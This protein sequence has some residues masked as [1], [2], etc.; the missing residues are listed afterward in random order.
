MN[1]LAGLENNPL[2]EESKMGRMVIASFVSHITMFF[3]L[4][5]LPSLPSRTLISPLPQYTSVKLVKMTD[6][7]G[8]KINSGNAFQLKKAKKE[9]MGKEPILIQKQV[10]IKKLKI[11]KRSESKKADLPKKKPS[12]SSKP[13]TDKKKTNKLSRKTAQDQIINQKINDIREKIAGG[14]GSVTAVASGLKEGAGIGDIPEM[15]VYT[16]IVVD[17]IM[18]AWFLPPA[19]KEKALQKNLLTIINIR[20]DRNGIVSLRGIERKSGNSLYDN[21]ALAALNKIKSESFPPLPEVFR[22]SYLE[23]GIRFHPSN[24]GN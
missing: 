23:L 4:I 2:F 18:E 10:E 1:R 15:A 13:S 11:S 7:T 14:Q 17:R 24:T 6:L 5:Y 3:L 20:I 12:P 21:F 19:L 16:S 9:I 8:N 22:H